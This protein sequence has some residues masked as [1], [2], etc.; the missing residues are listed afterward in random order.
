MHD[1]GDL[2][3]DFIRHY[4]DAHPP[5]MRYR[6]GEDIADWQARFR[7]KI[8]ELLGPVPARVAPEVDVIETVSAPEHTRYSLRIRVNEFSRLPAQLLV[9]HGLAVNEQRAGL[10]ACHGHD[11][12][13][14]DSICGVRPEEEPRVAYALAAVRAGYVVLAPGWWGWPGRDGHLGLVGAGDRCNTV[15]NA[16]GMY[17][18][19]ILALHIQDGQAALDVLTAR[20]E[21][22]STRIGC[23]GNSYGGRMTMWLSIVD[24]RIRA[25]VPAGCLN[26]FRERSMKLSSCGI[27][28]PY[29]LL[30]YG[31]VPEL[32]SLI[33]PRPMQ[34]QAGALDPLITPADRDAIVDRVRCA[35]RL[36]SAESALDYVLHGEGHVLMWEKAA[37]FLTQ[38]L[39]PDCS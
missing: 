29:G 4:G 21:V 3:T 25:C 18:L 7:T 38:H 22:D 5:C 37:P 27:Q 17:G 26:C 14:V 28:Y 16:A 6:D 33:A 10:I 35:Y 8:A 9:P 39:G 19:N 1:S 15:Q 32:F 30:R 13:G 12:Y 36:R 34:L 11:R 20:P 2:F 31:D 24:P 23:L